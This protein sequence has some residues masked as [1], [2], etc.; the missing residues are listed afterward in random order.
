NGAQV[1]ADTQP[2]QTAALAEKA[3]KF[4]AEQTHQ[5][6]VPSYALWFD[7]AQIN[8]IEKKS[9]PEFFNN[10]NRSKTPA[11]YQDYRDFMINTYRLNP[12]E[13]LTV[14]AC[15]RNLAG[16]VCAIMRV[17]SFLEQW[18]LINYQV[19]SDTRPS[20][21]TPPYTGHFTITADTP[22]GLIPFQPAFGSQLSKEGT[23]AA[24]SGGSEKSAKQLLTTSGTLP[25]VNLE[26]R[27]NIYDEKGN[28]LRTDGSPVGPPVAPTIKRIYCF[29]CGI[30]TTRVRYHNLKTKTHDLCPSCFIEAR[31]PSNTQSADYVK[32]EEIDANST[33]RDRPWT[34]QE[35]L[36]L[37]EGLEMFEDDWGKIAEHVGSRTREQ[38]VA[39]FLQL[40]IEDPYLEKDPDSLGPLKYN[41]VPFS[42]AD[43]PV[44]SVVSFLASL[45]DPKVADAASKAAKAALEKLEGEKNGKDSND[46]KMEVDEGKGAGKEDI[47]RMASVTLGAIAARAQVF[48]TDQERL[49]TKLVNDLVSTQLKKLDLKMSKFNQLE[50][51]LELERR[52]LERNRQQLF[53]DRLALRKKADEVLERLERAQMLPP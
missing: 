22:R 53:L 37:L 36:L 11:V 47:Q 9:L 16:D 7:M 8:P 30:D 23:N 27:K 44:V 33:E 40:P 28:P 39:R 10:R 12:S 41:K 52:E 45:V 18:G 43:N 3:R 1:S 42:H 48:A 13:Y 51:V 29:T 4:L 14:T 24:V 19:D 25:H 21:I 15:R 50:R 31:F 35:T 5:I 2:S 49:M 32:M 38:C 17:H 20:S 6:V 46:D 26:I 34:D